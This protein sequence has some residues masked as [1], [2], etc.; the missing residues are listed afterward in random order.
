MIETPRFKALAAEVQR[1]F[2]PDPECPG[3]RVV[4]L[5]GGVLAAHGLRD[6]GSDLDLLLTWNAQQKF[7]TE[8][9]AEFIQG[10]GYSTY[11]LKTDAGDIEGGNLV[12]CAPFLS[13]WG[14]F[15]CAA[16]LE[17]GGL[18]IASLHHTV[19][20]KGFCGRDKD[21]EDIRLILNHEERLLEEARRKLGIPKKP[22]PTPAYTPPDYTKLEDLPDCRIQIAKD[23]DGG[24][25]L[26][27][28]TL[29]DGLVVLTNEPLHGEFRWHDVVRR[30]GT[31]PDLVYRR[32]K[33]K[34][35][36]SYTKEEVGT[37][38]RQA[39]L[40]AL[41][42]IGHPGFFS[43]GYGHVFL[44]DKADGE[45]RVRAAF[46]DLIDTLGIRFI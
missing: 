33:L 15:T 42:P 5:G 44:E 2:P 20:I 4:V 41:K 32:W 26:W 39:I 25:N 24:E 29:S 37:E 1:L 40:D 6:I 34:V 45:E 36:F 30:Q 31:W 35:Q 21:K 28:K 18:Y 11:R 23:N 3:P 9:K 12:S 17:K 19:A 16:P 8:H 10:D 14:V 38:V 22:D 7:I 27:G 43:S 46:G 13:N